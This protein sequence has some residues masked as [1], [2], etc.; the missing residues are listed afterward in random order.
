MR[1]RYDRVILDCPPGLTETSEQVMR[2]ADAIIVPVIPSP[3]LPVFSMVDRR[4]ALHCEELA[5]SP[6]WPIIPMAS[7][8]EQMAMQRALAGTYAARSAAGESFTTLWR[9]V[10]R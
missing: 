4:R 6:D 9:G 5:A 8:I 10:E 7:V 1:K 2:A 3:L